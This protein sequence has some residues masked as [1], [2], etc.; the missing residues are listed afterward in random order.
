[1]YLKQPQ[2]AHIDI[3]G[4]LV[5]FDDG[6]G[7]GS[8]TPGGGTPSG[9]ALSCDGDGDGESGCGGG[10]SGGG[11]VAIFILLFFAVYRFGGGNFVLAWGIP[12]GN[13]AGNPRRL[14][15]N[16]GG[17][18]IFFFFNPGGVF[19]LGGGGPGG[20]GPRGSCVPKTDLGGNL[21]TLVTDI[22]GGRV[23][24]DFLVRRVKEGG[25]GGGSPG[26]G[27]CIDGG[28]GNACTSRC[29]NF[30][31]SGGDTPVGGI[32]NLL[33]CGTSFNEL[34]LRLDTSLCVDTRFP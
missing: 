21:V 22:P 11:G 12:G 9:I 31:S 10:G 19:V 3:P 17:G 34:F 7:G 26:G 25:P 14:L 33:E 2:T 32:S 27:G 30:G 28:G 8:G 29:T 24:G 16:P 15:V 4:G 6:G 1:M 23:M 5:G 20:G 13:A 18:F